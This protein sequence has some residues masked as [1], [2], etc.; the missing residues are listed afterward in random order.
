MSSAITQLP[1]RDRSYWMRQTV[2]ARAKIQ[3]SRLV[4]RLQAFAMNQPDKATGQQVEMTNAQ[5]RAALGLLAK[6]LPDLKESDVH[7]HNVEVSDPTAMVKRLEAMLGEEQAG[8]ILKRLGFAQEAK[9]ATDVEVV[10]G[11]G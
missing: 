5:V 7:H 10:H 1:K 6:V 11:E 3:A 8:V 9:S 4:D 2:N